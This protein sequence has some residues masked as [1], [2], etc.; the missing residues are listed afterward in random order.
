MMIE[1]KKLIFIFLSFISYSNLLAH[2]YFFAFAEVE[3]IED[4]SKIEATL[5]L[6]AHDFEEYL[7]K[8]RQLSSTLEFALTDSLETS[9]VCKNLTDHFSLKTQSSTTKDSLIEIDL[10][11]EGYQLLLNGNIEFYFSANNVLSH[12]SFLMKFDLLMDYFPEQQNKVTFLHQ[13]KKKTL[14]FLPN[15]RNQFIELNK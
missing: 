1:F 7:K 11:F 14:E 2:N 13:T 9:L 15:S 8:S 5:V 12:N 4:Q 6:T 3:Y 10:K